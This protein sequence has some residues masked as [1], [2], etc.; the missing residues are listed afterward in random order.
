MTHRLLVISLFV[1]ALAGCADASRPT[2]PLSTSDLSPAGRTDVFR[3]DTYDDRGISAGSGGSYR[4]LEESRTGASD[5][6]P[7]R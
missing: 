3:R 7:R 6:T 4:N 5:P 2:R 1:A